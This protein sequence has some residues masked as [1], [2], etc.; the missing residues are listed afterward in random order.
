MCG[1]LVSDAVSASPLTLLLGSVADRFLSFQ[2]SKFALAFSRATEGLRRRWGLERR[3]GGGSGCGH[4]CDP[5][6]GPAVQGEFC[7]VVLQRLVPTVQTV[8]KPTEFP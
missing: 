3:G 6:A 7:A 4:P 5:A 8:P 2:Q 1:V